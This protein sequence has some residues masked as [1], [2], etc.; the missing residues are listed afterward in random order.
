MDKSEDYKSIEKIML[1][2]ESHKVDFVLKDNVLPID[3]EIHIEDVDCIK[4]DTCNK[5]VW[6]NK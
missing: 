5:I 1:E 6:K 4:C 2:H 3:F